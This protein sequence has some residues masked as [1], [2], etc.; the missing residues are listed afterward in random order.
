MAWGQWTR[1]PATAEHGA[2]MAGLDLNATRAAA[3][4]GAPSQPPRPIRWGEGVD[5]L[6]LALSLERRAPEVGSAALA[7]RRR[8][9]HQFC[10]GFLPFLGQP[11]TWGTGRYKVHAAS[12][13]AH[14]AERL[15]QGLA[16]VAGLA[17]TLPAYLTSK[18][19][20]LGLTAL[21]AIRLPMHG[22]AALPLA[23]A[24]AAGPTR[25]GV[26]LVLD[27]DDFALT[28]SVLDSDGKVVRLNGTLTLPHLGIRAWVDRLMVAVADRCVRICRRDP[29]DSA[30]A[31]QSLDEQLTGI[32][33]QPRPAKPW[34][35]SVRTEHWYQTLSYPP[36]EIDRVVAGLARQA[37]DAIRPA[38]DEAGVTTMP[39]VVWATA[40]ASH[41]PGL[42]GEA[43]LRLPDRTAVEELPTHAPAMAAHRLA[44]KRVAGELPEGHLEGAWPFPP[45]ER[46]QSR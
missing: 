1:K 17:I 45:A 36:E 23:L 7:L 38:L 19:V 32:V 25:R 9:P 24:G 35:L 16:G 15:R 27:A 10:S 44:L 2:A 5:E 42:L 33:S 41:L 22:S 43:S 13:L 40:A 20:N 34:S 28:W 26:L 11:R 6:P 18:Q 14:V 29:R 21:E 37:A 12:A 8:S 39:D 46:V 4:F 3:M 31:E 30:S